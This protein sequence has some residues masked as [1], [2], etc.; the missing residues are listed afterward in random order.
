MHHAQVEVV[1]DSISTSG[2]RITTFKARYWRGIHS[3]LMTHR[4]LSKCAGSSR[5]RPSQAIIDQVESNPWGPLEFGSNQGGMQAGA[6]FEGDQLKRAEMEWKIA[7]ICA[8]KNAQVMADLGLHK[9]VVNRVLEP[10]T[11]IDVVITGT[12]FNNFFALRIHEAAD[13]TIRDLA[14]RM[15][16]AKDDSTPKLLGEDDWH[17][18]F[19]QEDDYGI[20]RGYLKSG[21]Q[22]PSKQELDALLIKISVARCARTSYKAF[23][24]SVQ[25]IEKDLELYNKLVGSQPLHATPAEHQAQ[26]D[27]FR[28]EGD[29]DDG[30]LES[31]LHGNF[32]GWKQYRKMLPNEY[33]PG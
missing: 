11:Y 9:Q 24:G 25:P 4:S 31:S 28:N 18:P 23:G 10:Y 22:L 30:W 21:G 32:V 16:A 6:L 14:V 12:E 1:A 13:P 26:P 7:A 8:A 33:V 20:A 17:L 5:A 19:I 27:D 15:K 2:K 29:N 3:E